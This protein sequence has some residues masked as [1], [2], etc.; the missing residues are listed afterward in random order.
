M[1]I[2]NQIREGC[3]IYTDEAFEQIKKVTLN[4]AQV[5]MR[6]PSVNEMQRAKALLE[7]PDW[8]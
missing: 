4:I 1:A 7:I 5:V 3:V 8:V 2:M 6:Q